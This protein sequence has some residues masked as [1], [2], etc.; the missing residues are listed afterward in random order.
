[1]Y[2]LDLPEVP[3]AKDLMIEDAGA[4]ASCERRTV[5]VDLQQEAWPEALLAAGH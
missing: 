2:E 3:E 1:L 5:G 4:K